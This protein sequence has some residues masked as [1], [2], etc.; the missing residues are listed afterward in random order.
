MRRLYWKQC[1]SRGLVVGLLEGIE[2]YYF[3]LRVVEGSREELEQ[4]L[5]MLLKLERK[6][7]EG[8]HLSLSL[9][10][11]SPLPVYITSRRGAM[12]SLTSRAAVSKTELRRSKP[13]CKETHQQLT[14]CRQ[15]IPLVAAGLQSHVMKA[16]TSL[17][18]GS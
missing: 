12:L 9:S 13:I 5:K 16:C 15:Y 8:Q 18:C 1:H 14:I 2:W 10:S 4:R 6:K 7:R 3:A 17:C 11:S